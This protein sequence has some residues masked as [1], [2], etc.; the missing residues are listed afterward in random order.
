[1]RF[2]KARLNK[3]SFFDEANINLTSDGNNFATDISALDSG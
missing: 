2:M 3:Y 1:M